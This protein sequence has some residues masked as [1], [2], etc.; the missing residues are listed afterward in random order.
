MLCC[1]GGVWNP[2]ERVNKQWAFVVKL[3]QCDGGQTFVYDKQWEPMD[4]HY[5]NHK[6][7]YSYAMK[8]VEGYP[9]VRVEG[10]KGSLIFFDCTRYHRVDEVLAGRRYSMGGFVGLLEDEQRLIVWS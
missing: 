8:V 5:F 3:T 6:D 9:E 4:E 7:N 10:L 1:Y 2:F